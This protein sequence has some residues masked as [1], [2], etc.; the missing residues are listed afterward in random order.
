[1]NA[2]GIVGIAASIVTVALIWVV[3]TGPQTS[4]VIRAA[5]ESFAGAIRAAQGRG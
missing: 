2:D 1:M 4:A 3:V 5:G